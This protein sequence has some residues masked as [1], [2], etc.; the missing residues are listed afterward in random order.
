MSG[1]LVLA[2]GWGNGAQRVLCVQDADATAERLRPL[3]PDL[4]FL[5][6]ATGA[7]ALEQAR[8]ALFDLYI[9][10]DRLPDME[11]TALC[12]EIRR[13]DPY[14]P[15][16]L[17]FH[18]GAESD[19]PPVGLAGAQG[20]IT[21]PVDAFTGPQVVRNSLKFSRQRS[22][23]ARAAEFE[24]VQA[25]LMERL[26]DADDHLEG[27]RKTLLLAHDALLMSRAY[28]AFARAGGMRA[29]FKRM[30]P[31]LFAQVRAKAL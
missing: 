28:D 2:K 1:G 19:H 30:W 22:I 18:A 13:F 23:E 29:D 15:V 3:L 24:A 5:A 21:N 9:V 10:A 7:A 6:V 26:R 4:E 12:R 16:L 17:C 11:G 14:T 20:Y 31:A 25:E 8:D 27:A